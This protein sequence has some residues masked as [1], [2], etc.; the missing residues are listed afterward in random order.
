MLGEL[1]LCTTVAHRFGTLDA[2]TRWPTYACRNIL[3]HTTRQP[4]QTTHPHHWLHGL[5]QHSRFALLLPQGPAAENIVAK[6]DKPALSPSSTTSTNDHEA[7]EGGGKSLT[8]LRNIALA[9]GLF[10]LSFGA[11]L[12]GRLGFCPRR[13]SRDHASPRHTERN[14]PTEE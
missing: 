5:P 7:V 3:S 8:S 6:I 11:Y 13:P 2:F 1:L 4:Q 14:N 12:P 10:I 9:G